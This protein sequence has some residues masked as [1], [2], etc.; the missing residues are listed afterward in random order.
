MC[1]SSCSFC[2]V[3]AITDIIVKKRCECLLLLG[4]VYVAETKTCHVESNMTRLLRAGK[5]TGQMKALLEDRLPKITKACAVFV[6]SMC[7][8]SRV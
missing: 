6:Q 4:E 1:S 3:D 2:Q 5:V 8:C 7:V